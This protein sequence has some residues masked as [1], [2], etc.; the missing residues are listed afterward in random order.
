MRTFVALPLPRD[1]QSVLAKTISRL[2]NFA[3]R[4]IRFVPAGQIHLTMKFLGEIDP[5]RAPAISAALSGLVL[6]HAPWSARL[7]GL[8]GF[9]GRSSPRVVWV[10]IE[11][12]GQASAMQAS[13]EDALA[14]LGHEREA[15]AFTPHLTLG[16]RRPGRDG[17]RLRSGLLDQVRVEP[18]TF[19]FDRLVLFTSMLTP[20]GAVHEEISTHPLGGKPCSTC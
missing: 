11:D 8:G 13:V 2:D 18:V 4:S 15:R 7:S 9:P 14:V 5:D 1:V 16:R 3:A 6:R 10:G 19:V 17:A 20:T 12:D